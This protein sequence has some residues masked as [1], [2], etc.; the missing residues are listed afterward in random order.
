MKPLTA[1][2]TIA[3]ATVLATVNA[4]ALQPY[5]VGHTD[6]AFNYAQGEW[7]VEIERIIGQDNA[8]EPSDVLLVVAPSNRLEIIPEDPAW[9]GE[10]G[11]HVWILPKDSYPDALF[12]GMNSEGTNPADFLPNSGRPPFTANETIIQL[13]AVDG[14]GEFAI[15]QPF[16]S[17]P[18]YHMT[19]YNGIDDS[20]FFPLDAGG[21]D[22]M[23]WVFTEPGYYE[24]TMRAEATLANGQPTQSADATLRF[25]VS[26][27]RDQDHDGMDDQWEVAYMLDPNVNDSLL[28]PDFDERVNIEEYLEAT[29]PIRKDFPA[30]ILQR[31]TFSEGEV[32][33]PI[34]TRFERFYQVQ[35]SKDLSSWHNWGDAFPG[36]GETVEWQPTR[37]PPVALDTER[38]YRVVISSPVFPE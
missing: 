22:H 4:F 10:E 27:F 12:L 18:Y 25:V 23:A 31:P 1:F 17:G 2:N 29:S 30:A 21:H 3:A 33:L 11:G 24:I 19:S 9:F 38:F 28:D 14:P 13:V 5:F 37:V 6:V 34:D 8:L 15:F 32:T 26:D 20:D 36:I 16:T 35:V 7:T